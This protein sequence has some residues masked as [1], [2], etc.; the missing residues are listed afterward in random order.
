M[1]WWRNFSL[2]S[3]F[4]EVCLLH[5]KSLELLWRKIVKNALEVNH[6]FLLQQIRKKKNLNKS[7]KFTE[8]SSTTWFVCFF[9]FVC[10]KPHLCDVIFPWN[11]PFPKIRFYFFVIGRIP[12][13]FSVV[14]FLAFCLFFSFRLS[15]SATVFFHV[16]LSGVQIG[17]PCVFNL[18]M[19]CWQVTKSN[20][21]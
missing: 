2:L 10:L 11:F 9:S 13:A 1:F 7:W 20:F 3:S 18:L 14:N 5:Q 6:Q 19:K 17:N 4:S 8:I 16:I 21:Q 12:H 15:P